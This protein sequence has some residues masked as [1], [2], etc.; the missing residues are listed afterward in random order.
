MTGSNSKMLSTDV[1]TEFRGRGD[2]VRVRPL[3]FAEYMSGFDGD[4]YGGW[5][6]YVLYGGM[7]LVLSMR[8]D[9]QK[10]R[11]LERL[12]AETYLKDIIARNGIENAGARG[13]GECAGVLGWF[14][15]EPVAD[16]GDV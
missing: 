9:Q 15:G 10:S 3:S 6:E 5:A 2:E 4:R 8:S 14:A 1:L 7:P 12:F 16:R 11:Y 13:L